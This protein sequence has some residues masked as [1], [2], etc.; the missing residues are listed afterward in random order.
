MDLTIGNGN[1]G[2]TSCDGN[3]PTMEENPFNY[4]SLVMLDVSRGALGE[5]TEYQART[6]LQ[7]FSNHT[8]H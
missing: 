4:N 2:N 6:I 5:D 7:Y 8:P 3:G 1:S